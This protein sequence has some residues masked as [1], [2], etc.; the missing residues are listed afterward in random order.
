[1]S[2][3][4]RDSGPVIIKEGGSGAGWFIGIVLVIAIIA[5]IFAFSQFN[6]SNTAKDNAVVHAANNV[7]DA[8]Q[9]VGNAADNAA[10]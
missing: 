8:A 6:S 2:D 5:G 4:S 3:G 7:G 10:N 1:M 9:R